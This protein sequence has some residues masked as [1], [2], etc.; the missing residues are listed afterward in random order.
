MKTT[1]PDCQGSRQV[2]QAGPTSAKKKEK[3]LDTASRYAQFF[4]VFKVGLACETID[5]DEERDGKQQEI[6]EKMN[7]KRLR[8]YYL[9]TMSR[10]N[11]CVQLYL[12]LMLLGFVTVVYR[13][14]DF[15]IFFLACVW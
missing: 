8:V 10:V 12:T 1:L 13:L 2:S 11:A 5:R 7:T 14:L 15:F 9:Y 4:P 6:V 3:S